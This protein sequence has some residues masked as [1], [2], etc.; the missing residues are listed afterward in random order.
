MKCK[1]KNKE[2]KNVCESVKH[3]QTYES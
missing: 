1:G 2:N 3:N